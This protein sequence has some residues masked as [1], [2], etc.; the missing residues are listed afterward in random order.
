MFT[1]VFM[2]SSTAEVKLEDDPSTIKV[3]LDYIYTNEFVEPP[4]EDDV[5]EQLE[6]LLDQLEKSEKWL[7]LSFK[8]SMENY[9]SDAHWIR[10]ETVKSILRCSRTYNADRLARVCDKYIMD[11]RVIVERAASRGE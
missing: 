10:P 3:L 6:N 2:E 11:N 1:S 5:T 8:R 9:L 7:L 4:H